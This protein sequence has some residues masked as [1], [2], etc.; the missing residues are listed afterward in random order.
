M[1]GAVGAF[2]TPL[3]GAAHGLVG[4]AKQLPNEGGI[5]PEGGMRPDAPLPPEPN[6]PIMDQAKS[7]YQDIKSNVHDYF[8]KDTGSEFHE[9]FKDGLKTTYGYGK[10]VADDLV[11]TANKIKSFVKNDMI[12]EETAKDMF[13]SLQ[14]FKDSLKAQ[15]DEVGTRFKK[16]A[17]DDSEAF[18]RTK[19][20]TT[21]R[22]AAQREADASI[23][24]L[25]D[26]IKMLENDETG[27]GWLKELENQ[28]T[29]LFDATT[30]TEGSLKGGDR[31]RF[32][33][34]E[35][36]VKM[37]Q[38]YMDTLKQIIEAGHPAAQFMKD[39][40][41]REMKNQL[42]EHRITLKGIGIEAAIFWSGVNAEYSPADKFCGLFAHPEN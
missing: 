20:E 27:E 35:G 6:M 21:A 41:I 1:A 28:N 24:A 40:I 8:N 39:E 31:V 22:Y 10:F 33:D 16:M 32:T 11:S 26:K 30:H 36:S 38:E 13:D 3:M 18:V 42:R 25:K 2:G 14:G 34:E 7:A 37:N 29:I 17:D 9:A 4:L 23:T 19:G 12:G 15:V 5:M